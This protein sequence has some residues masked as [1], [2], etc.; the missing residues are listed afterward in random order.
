MANETPI[1][2]PKDFEAGKITM[3]DPKGPDNKAKTVYMNYESNKL[4]IQ[5]PEMPAPFGLSKWDNKDGKAPKYS[6]DISFKEH[7]SRP[8]VNKFLEVVKSLD[9]LVVTTAIKNKATWFKGKKYSDETVQN[10]YTPTLKYA[11]D[12]NTK[13]ITDAY[14][15]TFKA[16]LP[17]D[18]KENRITTK[19]YDNKKTPINLMEDYNTKGARVALIV[20][21][22]GVWISA[23]GFGVSWRALQARISP[24][25]TIKD[26]AFAPTEED[27]LVEESDVEENDANDDNKKQAKEDNSDGKDKKND[28]R[29]MLDDDDDL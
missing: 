26:Y 2:L 14:P 27:D 7:D 19:V 3:S 18:D 23:T 25:T 6:L 13:E 15:P 29:D 9:E 21:C 16:A 11:K 24:P 5:T 4:I 12:K 22:G 8:A 20:Q 10:L 17:F 28:G 1:L